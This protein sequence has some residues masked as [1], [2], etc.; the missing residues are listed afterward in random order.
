MNLT[1]HLSPKWQQR[2]GPAAVGRIATRFLPFADAAT[3]EL[4]L[5]RLLRL[6]LFQIT[7]GMAAVL[8]TATL[9]RVMIV[10]LH[11]SALLVALMVSIP[12]LFAPARALI[13]FKSDNHR[14]ALG[15][16]RVPYIW[17]GTLLHFGGFAILPFALLVMSGKGVFSAHYGE[18]GAVLGFLLV[19]AGTATVQTAG[20]ALATDIA[21][22]ESRPRVVSLLYVMLLVGML[23]SSL[24]IGALL[25]DFSPTRLVQVVQ[26]VGLLTML[27]NLTALWKQEARTARPPVP[28]VAP[29]FRASWREFI[30]VPR[31]RRLL[32]AVGLG[33]AAFAMQDVLLEPFGGQILHLT[34]GA[35][36][37]LTSLWATGTLLGLALAAKMLAQG[38]DPHRLA[39]I[40]AAVG[41]L[42]FTGVIFAGALVEPGLLR[43]GAAGIGFGGGLFAVGTMTAAM[44]LARGGAA[45]LALGAWGAVQA[46][47]AGLA[48]LAGGLLK[49]IAGSIALQGGFGA[50]LVGPATGY[51]AVYAL[52]IGLLFLTIVALGPLA[53]STEDTN[54]SG[55]TRGRF[56]L[57]GFPG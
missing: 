16:K 13:G 22:A 10:E 4:P 15:W 9:N 52:E 27:L 37:V 50:A 24:V 32:I 49:D 53:R 17:F 51:G 23:V 12:L 35:T 20:L 44:A 26:G 46:T 54:D 57:A 39:G 43:A 29:D 14:S 25:R 7:C 42:A 1:A 48:I 5:P 2:L 36:T 21:P 28:E 40:G 6:S 38:H 47:C 3:P 41:T 56:G 18:A 19:G 33:A 30:T 8:L 45:G 55:D 31:H 34:V 11:M